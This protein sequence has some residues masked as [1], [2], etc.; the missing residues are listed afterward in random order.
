MYTVEIDQQSIGSTRL[1]L[2]RTNRWKRDTGNVYHDSPFCFCFTS[3]LALQ[4]AL[5]ALAPWCY[6]AMAL[7][8]DDG[9][10]MDFV[11]LA[12]NRCMDG[13]L[14]QQTKTDTDSRE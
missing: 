12:I 14:A 6:V 13:R 10:R 4:L 2:L 3:L 11:A 9:K 1:S 8:V 7:G 5:F